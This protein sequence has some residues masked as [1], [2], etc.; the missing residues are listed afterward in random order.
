MF[1]R[2]G[3]NTRKNHALAQ[4]EKFLVA[5]QEKLHGREPEVKRRKEDQ[6][7]HWVP[8][9]P[10]VETK[11]KPRVLLMGDEAL[12]SIVVAPD[13][14]LFYTDEPLHG[15]AFVPCHVC[16]KALK[17]AGKNTYERM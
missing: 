14:R 7:V 17:A 2:M 9:L 12:R 8:K 4:R 5:S 1:L 16:W 13:E 11:V 15:T 10:L 6:P 3:R